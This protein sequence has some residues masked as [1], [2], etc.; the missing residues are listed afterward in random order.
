MVNQS[1]A[2]QARPPAASSGGN[3]FAQNMQ[4]MNMMAQRA[5][6]ERQAQQ[7]QQTMGIQAAQE[8]R[9]VAGEARAATQADIDTADKRLKYFR[10]RATEV[11]TREGYENW[12]AEVG[13][14][15]PDF[16]KSFRLNLPPEKF[17][18]ADLTSMIGDY[19]DAFSARFGKATTGVIYAADGTVLGYN[20]SGIPGA[21]SASPLP[22]ISQPLAGGP[23]TG[24]PPMAAPAPQMPA[25]QPAPQQ[26]PANAMLRPISATGGQP[27]GADPQDALLAS[28]TEAAKSKQ[29]GQD[30]VQQLYQLA[31]PQA[32]PA[33]DKFL[34]ENGIQVSPGGGMRSAVYR[35]EGNAMAPQQVQYNPNAYAPV[36]AKNPMQSPMPGSAIVPLPRVAG[37]ASAE[38]AGRENVRVNTQPKIVAGEERVRRLEK[39]RGD[40]PRAL[41][42]AQ[43]LISDMDSKIRAIDEYLA[44]PDRNA[45]I[46]SVEGRIPKALQ[47]ERRATTQALYDSI[48]SNQVLNELIKGRQATETGASPMGIVSDRDL[49]I[50][51][52][53]SNRLTQIGGERAQEIEMQRLRDILYKTRQQAAQTYGSTFREVA[54]DAPELM[55]NVPPIPE[56]YKPP[57]SGA[58]LRGAQSGSNIDALLKK[59]GG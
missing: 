46:G 52:A 28:L 21:S 13:K 4:M 53:A 35:Q 51:A 54:K 27:G 33:V 49:A 8:G 2:L 32:T 11:R 40:Q 15:G 37:E 25:S 38:T 45:I 18:P 58:S 29:I 12:L 10:N 19:S 47:S 5:A 26:Q 41:S 3:A 43:T 59:Y 17:T 57:A 48:V 56:K 16:A 42:D 14:E 30:V 22:D 34:S 9:A 1:I 36:R 50:A 44:S 39:L 55:L 20:A 6:A 24:A 31:G 7:S 23:Q